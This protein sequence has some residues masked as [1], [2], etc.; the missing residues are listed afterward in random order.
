MQRFGYLLLLSCVYACGKFACSKANV[1]N[2]VIDH[3]HFFDN[4]MSPLLGLSQYSQAVLSF[5][6]SSKSDSSMTMNNFDMTHQTLE[7]TRFSTEND[8]DIA[9]WIRDDTFGYVISSVLQVRY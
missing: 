2:S 6:P 1:T 7:L 8:Q 5:T 3:H 4:Y 9:S